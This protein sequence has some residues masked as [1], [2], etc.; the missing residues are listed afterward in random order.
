MDLIGLHL[1]EGLR[2][3][4]CPVCRGLDKFERGV[5]ENI[6]YEGVNDPSLRRKF[7]ESLGLCPYHAWKL[8]EVAH[9]NPL[10]GGLGVAT[11][12]EDMLRT[13]ISTLEEN[14]TFHEGECY[15]CSLLE[16]KER[17]LVES[18]AE[19]LEELLDEYENSS[20]VLCRRHYSMIAELIEDPH[21]KKRLRTVQIKKLEKLHGLIT[22]F[23]EKFDYRSEERP[24]DEEIRAVR[25]T[26]E[27]LKGLP[28]PLKPRGKKRGVIGFVWRRDRT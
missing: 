11:I 9:S 19:R 1:R 13:Y 24:S 5:I 12:Y 15:L 14:S 20:A 8:F 27:A 7:R 3:Y 17:I 2:G 4:G 22:S 18:F 10:Y 28:L 23:I 6:L 26:V 16:E 21:L 25:G